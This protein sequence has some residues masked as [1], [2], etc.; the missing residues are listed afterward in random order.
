[1][2]GKT[3]RIPEGIYEVGRNELAPRDQ[4]ISR[5][6]FLVACVD[7][8]LYVQDA[9]SANKTYVAQLLAELPTRLTSGQELRLA[10]NTAL[11]T[12]NSKG[13]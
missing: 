4:H 7:G 12:S 11:Y 1:M 2:T 6:H 9:G 3:F 10:D 13:I 5:R 8:H